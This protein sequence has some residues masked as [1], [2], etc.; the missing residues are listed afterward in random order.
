MNKLRSA[1][2]PIAHG[3]E[4]LEAVGIIDVLR[5]AAIQVTVASVEE[6][7]EVKASRGVRLVADCFVAECTGEI[8]DLIAL[9][10]GMPGAEHL[11]DNQVL[12]EMLQQQKQS[13]RLYGAIC[14]APAVVL[15]FHNLLPAGAVTS[16]PG[17]WGKLP[18]AHRVDQ[19]VVVTENCITSQGPGTVLEFALTL[20]ELL[21]GEA[22]RAQVAAPLIIPPGMGEV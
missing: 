1:L 17:H 22:T 11:R 15:A 13:G 2:V 7:L 4:E 9:P 21:C 5:R 14:A 18:A 8:F 6:S 10:G 20:V 3:T 19:R 12:T 16:H